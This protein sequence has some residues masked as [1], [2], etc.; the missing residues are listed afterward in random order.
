MAPTA[1]PRAPQHN[2][3]WK[4]QEPPRAERKTRLQCWEAES[5]QQIGIYDAAIPSLKR[6][7]LNLFLQLCIWRQRSQ[8]D[9]PNCIFSLHLSAPRMPGARRLRSRLLLGLCPLPCR[10]LGRGRRFCHRTSNKNNS[11]GVLHRAALE[12]SQPA[13]ERRCSGARSRCCAV[14]TTRAARAL[15]RAVQHLVLGIL[16]VTPAHD[17]TP[18]CGTRPPPPPPRSLPCSVYIPIHKKQNKRMLPSVRKPRSG[19]ETQARAVRVWAQES[20]FSAQPRRQTD[21]FGRKRLAGREAARDKG[22]AA[23][24]GSRG[25]TLETLQRKQK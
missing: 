21:A 25:Q 22:R 24:P 6:Q 19:P 20:P 23:W 9:S 15:S 4:Q 14:G 13:K 16:A 3:P 2:G 1:S 18:S 12:K 11:P 5:L 7:G 17:G 10:L 8:D